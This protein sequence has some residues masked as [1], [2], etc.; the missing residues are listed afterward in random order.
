MA[1]SKVITDAIIA[2][3]ER[4]GGYVDAATLVEVARAEDHPAHSEL[5]PLDRDAAFREWQ[6]GK[7]GQLIASARISIRT[8]P[9]QPLRKVPSFVK[10][11]EQ[12][13]PRS[14]VM[15]GLA[16]TDPVIAVASVSS[17]V[18]AARR[19]MEKAVVIAAALNHK[20]EA[21]AALQTVIDLQTLLCGGHMEIPEPPPPPPPPAGRRPRGRPRGERRPN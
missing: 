9:L 20:E 14:Y 7:A 18:S 4:N 16:A 2:L 6:L 10:I 15:I 8:H 11:A 12:D 1:V 5:W 3:A 19:A 13:R 17:Y 21:M